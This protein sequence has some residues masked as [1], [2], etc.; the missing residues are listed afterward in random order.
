MMPRRVLLLPVDSELTQT[1]DQNLIRHFYETNTYQWR[2]I[3]FTYPFVEF[4]QISIGEQ[5]I[6]QKRC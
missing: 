5:K 6:A 4:S 3:F 1:K 2:L